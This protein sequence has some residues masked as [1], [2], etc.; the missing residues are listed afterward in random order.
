MKRTLVYAS[1]LTGLC[2]VLS[3]ATLALSG[4]ST[5]GKALDIVNPSY[6]IRGIRPHVAFALPLSA[7]SIDLDFDIG[8]D[9]PNSVGLNL[10]RIDFDVLVNDNPLLTQVSTPQAVHIPARGLGNVH[11]KTRVDY[12]SIRNIWS[13]VTDV[14]AGNKARY[15]IRG[16]AYYNT[17]IGQMRFPVT[18]YSR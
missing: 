12:Q 3:A 17:P 18:V 4:C 8:V 9:N 1:L 16:N 7:S 13:Q 15:Q 11:L 6:S 5:I 14:I 10:E 2:L